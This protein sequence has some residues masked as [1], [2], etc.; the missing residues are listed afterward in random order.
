MENI[1][2]L[3]ELR[4]NAEKYIQEVQ[5]GKSFTVVRRSRPIFKISPPDND[6]S[7]D[8]WESV[9]DFTTLQKGGV[10]LQDLLSRL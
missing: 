8:T 2:G 5:K 4:E 6:G 9:V 1:V 3:K 10:K 7:E